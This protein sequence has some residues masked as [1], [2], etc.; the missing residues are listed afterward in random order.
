MYDE[1]LTNN[2]DPISIIGRV[3]QQSFPVQLREAA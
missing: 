1:W 2:Y 3:T